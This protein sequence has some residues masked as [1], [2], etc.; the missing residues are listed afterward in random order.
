MSTID[1]AIDFG[2]VIQKLKVHP[3]LSPLFEGRRR[4]RG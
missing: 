3:P 2:I 4:N 1:F